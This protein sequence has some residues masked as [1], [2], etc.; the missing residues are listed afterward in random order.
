MTKFRKNN[1]Q[2]SRLTAE[3]NDLFNNFKSV[4]T[5]ANLAYEERDRQVTALL[6]HLN[7]L[8][9][10]LFVQKRVNVGAQIN[11][12][13]DA[14]EKIK[15]FKQNQQDEDETFSSNIDD[16]FDEMSNWSWGNQ[17]QVILN[18]VKIRDVEAVDIHAA[19]TAFA[20]ASA[21]IS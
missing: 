13:K 6:N 1:A 9:G 5:Q 14:L 2:T 16:M 4:F 17:S 18:S 11:R 19:S 3:I 15:S 8:A 20:S 10:R 21:S 12:I 7:D